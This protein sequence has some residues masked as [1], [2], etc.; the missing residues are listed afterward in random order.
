MFE[1]IELRFSRVCE[2]SDT[3][4]HDNLGVCRIKIRPPVTRSG[5]GD[6]RESR[7]C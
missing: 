3:L 7:I 1:I 5:F 2:K 6:S 4:S